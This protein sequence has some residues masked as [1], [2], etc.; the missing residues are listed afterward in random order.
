MPRP[1][2]PSADRCAPPGRQLAVG[3]PST[4]RVERKGLIPLSGVLPDYER[5]HQSGDRVATNVK[6]F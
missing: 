3:A 1:A 6:Y 5:S 2:T 4:P